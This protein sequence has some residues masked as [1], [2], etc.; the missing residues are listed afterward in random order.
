M[1]FIS[2]YSRYV[3]LNYILFFS[4]QWSG[5]FQLCCMWQMYQKKVLKVVGVVNQVSNMGEVQ[6]YAFKMQIYPR[7]FLCQKFKLIGQI[8]TK[9]LPCVPIGIL[10]R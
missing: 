4:S 6:F 9:L 10:G 1:L 8:L 5:S 2:V 3:P 7:Q